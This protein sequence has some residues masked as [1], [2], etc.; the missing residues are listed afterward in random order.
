MDT[1]QPSTIA[2]ATPKTPK[3]K[4]ITPVPITAGSEEV[5]NAC[6]AQHFNLRFTNKTSSIFY[7]SPIGAILY[8]SAF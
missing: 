2:S 6:S 4:R 7:F 3:G 5:R 8:F 1:E